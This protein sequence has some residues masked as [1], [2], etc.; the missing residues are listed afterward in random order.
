MTVRSQSKTQPL[1]SAANRT[2]FTSLYGAVRVY[3]RRHINGCRLAT[4]DHNHCSCPKWIYSK[5]RDGKASQQAASTPSFTEACG[6]AQKILKGFD[7][8]IRAAREQ[9]SA[10]APPGITVEAALDRYYGVLR[11]R[12]LSPD[13]MGGCI[14][15]VFDR[16]KPRP[17]NRGRRVLNLSLLDFLDQENRGSTEP[18]T[19]VEQI[20]SE[21]LDDW[22][23]AWESNDLTSKL[24][25][26]VATSFFRWSVTRGYL[27]KLPTF[28]ERQRIKP[29]NRCGYFTDEQS[30]LILQAL[31]FYRARRGF[32]PQNYAQRLRAF[33]DLGRWAGMAVADIVRFSPRIN[34]SANNVLTYRRVKSGQMAVIL[35]DPIVAARLRSIPTEAG[36]SADAPFRFEGIAEDRS[37][38]IW[39]ERFQ[40]LCETVG[41][42]EIETETGTRRRPHPHMLRD[43]F[44]I[45]AI[46]RGVSLENVAKMLGHATVAMTQ[47]SYLFWI[48]K[49]LDYCIEDQRAA[50]TRVQVAAPLGSGTS[51]RRESGLGRTLVH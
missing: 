8:E 1:P 38:G 13:Y 39:R 41:I 24:W 4:A 33:I 11:S 18:V 45:D 15:P 37:R 25:R 17:G 14:T 50:L 5:A 47:R 12:K 28:G 30:G 10:V 6:I 3:T 20:S 49:R 40:K 32:M 19:R 51:G 44:A 9:I 46:T 42:T 7:P 48:Q 16:R 31:P 36:A 35:L 23:A 26:T 21:L 29:G 22:A 34:L 43:T 27:A 2:V